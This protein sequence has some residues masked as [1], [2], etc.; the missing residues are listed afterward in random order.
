MKTIIC[1]K[2]KN[3]LTALVVCIA[4]ESKAQIPFYVTIE[5]GQNYT[6]QTNQLVTLIGHDASIGPSVIGLLAD[7]TTVNFLSP[8]NGSGYVGG[9]FIGLT[10]IHVNGI[11]AV[12]GNNSAGVT[13]RI[14][15]Q[16]CYNPNTI[17]VIPQGGSA[18]VQV[19]TTSNLA[20][21]QW[22]PIFSQV[23]TNA[24]PTN[25]FFTFTLLAQ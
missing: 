20:S 22:T 18:L 19:Q 21:G 13:F 2:W 1:S 14:Q 6:V 9:P 12:P 25:Q 4:V 5:L 3:F 17:P 24:T 8:N 7:G 15:T 23:F 16:P 10:N 11:P